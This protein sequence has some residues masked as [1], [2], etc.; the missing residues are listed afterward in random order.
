VPGGGTREAEMAGFVDG[1]W[2]SVRI[3][4]VQRDRLMTNT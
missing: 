4:S 2:D 1:H 3:I